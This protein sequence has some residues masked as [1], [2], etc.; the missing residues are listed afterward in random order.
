MLHIYC[1]Q[2]TP[3]LLFYILLRPFTWQWTQKDR[4][5]KTIAAPRR[6]PIARPQRN[7]S[8]ESELYVLSLVKR[9]RKSRQ[10]FQLVKPKCLGTQF[11]WVKP[12]CLC[13]SSSAYPNTV[14]Q[15][16]PV[17]SA[18]PLLPLAQFPDPKDWSHPL[19][20]GCFSSR[21]HF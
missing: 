15:G 13:P 1:L 20:N 16:G 17:S 6:P 8:R 19:R 2:Y 10:L 12:Q 18:K 14:N 11:Q 3:H 9:P 4:T 7:Q 5:I 21:R